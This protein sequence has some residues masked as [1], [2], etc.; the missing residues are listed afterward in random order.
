MQLS[1]FVSMDDQIAYQMY[2]YERFG[3]IKQS[4]KRRRINSLIILIV[5][6]IYSKE[7][8]FSFDFII[9]FF[10]SLIGI[11]RNRYAVVQNPATAQLRDWTRWM[12]ANIWFI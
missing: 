9:A 7:G 1:Y 6:F 12:Y 10:L 4:V 11:E 2:Q 5:P 8:F 3:V